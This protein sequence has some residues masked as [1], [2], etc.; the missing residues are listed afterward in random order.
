ME[1]READLIDKIKTTQNVQ[2][3]EFTKLEEVLFE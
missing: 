3:A 2:M 1:S